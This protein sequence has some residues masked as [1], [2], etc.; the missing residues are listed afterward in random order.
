MLI[1]MYNGL[2]VYGAPELTEVVEVKRSWRERL[3]S[4]TPCVKTK[5]VTVPSLRYI[6][7]ADSKI[8]VHP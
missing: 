3:F 6:I 2:V 1:G 7:T 5:K 4:L 8:F